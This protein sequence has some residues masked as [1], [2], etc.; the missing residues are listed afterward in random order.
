MEPDNVAIIYSYLCREISSNGCLSFADSSI[1]WFN[2][3]SIEYAYTI[4][5][6]KLTVLLL[7][8]R[9]FLPHRWGTFD[10]ILRGFM[11]V[12]SL[13]YI[14]TAFLKVWECTPR[15]RIWNKTIDG[16]CIS[17]SGILNTDG[18]F[19]T[20]SDFLIIVVPIK[21]VW[22]LQV[23]GN[24]KMWIFLLFTVGLMLV[25]L[26]ASI[27]RFMPFFKTPDFC[28]KLS[29]LTGSSAPIFSIVGW[30]VRLRNSSNPDITHDQPQILLWG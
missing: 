16:T 27:I 10:I 15:P 1:E 4:L 7:Y 21:A 13:Y 6:T 28:L 3:T 29:I 23:K 5:C 2:A 14:I 18:V 25:I 11:L 30:V 24:K 8:R 17:V 9:V 22:T 12:V 20:L 26:V 19:N